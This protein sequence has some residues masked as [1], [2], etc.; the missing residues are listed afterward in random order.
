MNEIKVML[1]LSP[2]AFDKFVADLD[3]PPKPTPE[4]IALLSREPLWSKRRKRK[5]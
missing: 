1:K 5:S 2:E 4:L 3:A